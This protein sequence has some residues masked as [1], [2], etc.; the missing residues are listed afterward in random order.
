[1]LTIEPRNA[2]WAGG[3]AKVETRAQAREPARAVPANLK[4][5][6]TDFEQG[7]RCEGLMERIYT[8]RSGRSRLRDAGSPVPVHWRPLGW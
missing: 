7:T 8:G 1:M 3:G 4:F 6:T 5:Q 2:M